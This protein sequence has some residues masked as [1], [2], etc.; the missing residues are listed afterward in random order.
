MDIKRVITVVVIIIF[1]FI[2]YFI[3]G[4]LSFE[5]TKSYKIKGVDLSNQYDEKL[6]WDALKGTN[7]FVILRAVR[8][9]DTC[10]LKGQQKF[11]SKIDKKFSKNWGDLEAKK[12]TRG[13]Y[14]FFAPEIPAVEQFEIYKKAV[15]LHKGD[16]PPI[17]DVENKKC[18]MNEA[19]KWLDM[20]QKHYGVNPIL[21]T[22]YL[23]YKIFLGRKNL[24]YP[25]WIYINERFGFR[26]HFENPD[27]VIWQHKQDIKINDFE[28]A[29]DLNIFIGDSVEFKKLLI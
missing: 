6:N 12:I 7:D 13:A 2:C 16:L 24:K 8:A 29:I 19:I 25:T 26:P 9:I 20:A 28:E 27:C 22:D 1:A 15:K 17:L 5:D 21:Y 10:K 14:H 11:I 4:D 23:F 18:D 3:F